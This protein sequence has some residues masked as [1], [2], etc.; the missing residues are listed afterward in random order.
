MCSHC[1]QEARSLEGALDKQTSD[2]LRHPR[3]QDGTCPPWDVMEKALL[4]QSW[5]MRGNR[6]A[7]GG[8][9]QSLEPRGEAGG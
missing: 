9:I 2:H 3:C 4:E 7:V 6:V 5:K 8:G 1:P